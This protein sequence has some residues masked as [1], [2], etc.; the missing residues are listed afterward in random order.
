M[1]DWV[2]QHHDH[3]SDYGLGSTCDKSPAS[4]KCNPDRSSVGLEGN[5]DEGQA[6]GYNS[7]F[8]DAAWGS[9]LSSQYLRRESASISKMRLLLGQAIVG[10]EAGWVAVE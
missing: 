4:I 6:L 9:W 8:G 3:C 7:S 5:Q 10:I 1:I 2:G